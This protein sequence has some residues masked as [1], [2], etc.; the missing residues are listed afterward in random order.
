VHAYG[1]AADLAERAL[2]LWPRVPE[3]AE[4]TALDHVDLLQL[5]AEGHG[6]AGDRARAEVL[7]QSAL[8][9]LDEQADCRRY[10]I[11]LGRLARIQWTLNR[12]AEGVQS[13]QRALGMLPEGESTRERASLM[14]WLARTRFL[15]G[16][17]R[18]ALTDGEAALAAARVAGDAGVETEILNTLGMVEVALGHVPEGVTRLRRAMEIARAG[19]DIDGL[20]YVYTNLADLLNLRGRTVEGLATAREG[21]AAIPRRFTQTH[22]W[23]MLT[24]S[25]LA[26]ESGD[27]DDA[28]AKLETSGSQPVGVMLIFRLLREADLALGVGDDQLAEER[29][30]RAEPL[31]ASSS[32]PQWIGALGAMLGESRRRGRDLLGARRAVAEALDRLELCTDDV[33]RIARVTAT[34]LRIE[35]DIAQR[36]RDLKEPGE[37]RDAVARAR[38]HLQRLRAA[39][40]EGGPVEAAWQATGAAELARARGRSDPALWLKAAQQWEAMSR[41]Y[42]DAISQWRAA[43]AQV[44]SGDRVAATE[45]AHAGLEIARGLGSRWLTEEIETLC[46]RARLDAPPFR[47]DGTPTPAG[48]AGPAPDDPFGLTPRER[49]VLTLIAE[50]ATN[51]Q[52]GNALFMA[53][54]TAS[55]HVS[56]ILSKLGVRSRTQAAAVAHR[57]RLNA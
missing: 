50:G 25:E 42:H 19:G 32:E 23:A 49:Q 45:T 53:E 12:G 56:R 7:L 15:R 41:P 39:A 34:G 33:M 20:G 5:A 46:E 9:R 35:A 1:E 52:I 17:F 24:V 8:E 18:E 21:L 57:L 27:W 30:S 47:A 48:D 22:T 2:E 43:E 13:A 55:V 11:V 6:I 3:G 38:I 40:Q 4:L 28:R 54:K 26:L 37:A 44:E 16:R 14:S 29:L 31:V 10:A 51:R 36:A